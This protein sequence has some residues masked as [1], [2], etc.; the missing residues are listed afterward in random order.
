MFTIIYKADFI[1]GVCKILSVKNYCLA[2]WYV[3][4]A[5]YHVHM[6]NPDYNAYIIY[7]W[8]L[9]I[10]LYFNDFHYIVVSSNKSD[11]LKSVAV[12][13]GTLVAVLLLVTIIII[14]IIIVIVMVMLRRNN[15]RR[16]N[17]VEDNYL[18][19][20]PPSNFPNPT[21]NTSGQSQHDNFDS[22][23]MIAIRS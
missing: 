8:R 1:C 4:L 19:I 23:Y 12:I 10:E 11:D 3:A 14:I 6:H 16:E 15:S 9:S 22:K 2:I 21:H 17:I 20:L 7:H 5:F 13:S 18:T